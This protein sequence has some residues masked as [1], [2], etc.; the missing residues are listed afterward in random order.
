[1]AQIVT[2]FEERAEGR[3]AHVVVDN[4]AKLNVL[5]SALSAELEAAFRA[6]AADASLRAVVLAGAGERAMIGGAD[7]REMAGLNPVTAR[8]FITQ[9]HN[10]CGAIRA[11]PVPV[12]ARMRGYCLGGGLEIAAACDMR[13]ASD[14]AV[15]GMPEVRVGIPSV[16][17]AALL[18][19]LIGWGRTR[20]I[21]MTGETFGAAK[22]LEWGMVEEVVPAAELDAAIGR[23][24]DDLLAGAPH[25][26]RLQKK[27]IG[28][29]EERGMAGAIAAGIDCFA[30]A[31]TT[32]EPRV[33]MEAFLA[34]RRKG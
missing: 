18:P 29:W 5:N 28:E 16:I 3:V 33:R 12:V 8:D 14:D 17:E 24:L 1:M 2:T 10:V 34:H 19:Q 13:I 22:A 20:R 32:P 31:W 6:L 11:L 4:Q 23:V 26:I 21:V 7:I 25:A 27:L 15:M 30:E 9:L